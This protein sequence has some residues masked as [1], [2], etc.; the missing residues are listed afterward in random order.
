MKE[1]QKEGQKPGSGG[2]KGKMSAESLAKM[3]AEQAKLRE[4]LKKLQQQVCQEE[5]M[6]LQKIGDL[7]EETEKDIVNR[8]ITRETLL[9]QEKILTKL[10]ESEK[11]DKERDM[12]EKRESQEGK[13]KQ[14]GNLLDLNEYYKARN[15]DHERLIK[16]NF[17]YNRFYKDRVEEY[18]KSIAE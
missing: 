3:A 17:S 9:R 7:M 1:M 2:T 16:E 5:S 11:A 8:D 12:D 4:E 18:F 13:E 14:K 6:E 15:A 10:L